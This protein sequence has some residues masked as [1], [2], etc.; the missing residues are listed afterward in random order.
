ME[1]DR[2][3]DSGGACEAGGG[4]KETAVGESE[5]EGRRRKEGVGGDGGEGGEEEG[6]G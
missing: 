3:P 6:D 1:V 2:V 4:T 5:E